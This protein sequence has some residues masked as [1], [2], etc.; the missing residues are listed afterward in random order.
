[1]SSPSLVRCRLNCT[2][3]TLTTDAS[4]GT[5]TRFVY[6]K[7]ESIKKKPT[8]C[9]RTM[10]QEFDF[11][12]AP[13]RHTLYDDEEEED[14]GEEESSDGKDSLFA[15][16]SCSAQFK[17]GGAVLIAIGKAS[18]IFARSRLVLQAL[19]PS[20]VVTSGSGE[21]FKDAYFPAEKV[22]REC[23]EVT[24]SELYEAKAVALEERS[25]YVCIHEGELRSE[26][27]NLWAEKVGR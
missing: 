27:C 19:D 13:Q 11:F 16:S 6:S 14:E 23:S 5:H 17:S 22:S 4:P 18:A 24:V 8:T 26:C 21:V 12:P 25:A 15:V 2:V 1:M 7:T 9:H 10:Q 3:S 20:C